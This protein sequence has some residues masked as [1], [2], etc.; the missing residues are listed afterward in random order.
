M[1]RAASL[2]DASS[3][4]EKVRIEVVWKLAARF[5]GSRR[6]PGI[7]WLNYRKRRMVYPPA[8]AD[9]WPATEA[10]ART[11]LHSPEVLTRRRLLWGAGSLLLSACSASHPTI[12][13]TRV[14]PADKGGPDV[15]DVIEGRV[16]GAKPGQQIV[17]FAHG[18]VW[19]AEPR[20]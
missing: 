5:L 8:P 12:E 15:M 2:A 20:L 3:S 7:Y 1:I 4:E 6:A 13:F 19:W 14:P 10:A 17:V 9:V 18:E 11:A 16:R